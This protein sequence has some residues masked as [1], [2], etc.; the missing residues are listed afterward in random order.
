MINVQYDSSKGWSR[1]LLEAFQEFSFSPFISGL[2][3]GVQCYEGSKA[4]KNEKGEVRLFR[5]EA[6]A[7]RF[8]KASTR[9]TMAD[10]D[11]KE[12]INLIEEFVRV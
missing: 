2:H 6:N 5:L 11:G 4:Y 1:P 10:F 7:N 9:L 8:K 3:Y 12:L